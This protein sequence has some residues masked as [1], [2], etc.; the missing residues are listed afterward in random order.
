M[1]TVQVRPFPLA[2]LI[3]MVHSGLEVGLD[4]L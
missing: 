2:R 4:H 1:C 3:V